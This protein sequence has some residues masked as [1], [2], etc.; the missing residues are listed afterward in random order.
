MF[1]TIFI[2][3]SGLGIYTYMVMTNNEKNWANRAKNLYEYCNEQIKDMDLKVHVNKT[4]NDE[5]QKNKE[6]KVEEKKTRPKRM[7]K[8]HR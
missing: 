2:I 6:I 4:Y 5:V 1:R 3:I 7:P 8:L